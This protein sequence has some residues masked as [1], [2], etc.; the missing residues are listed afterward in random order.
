M[1]SPVRAGSPNKAHTVWCYDCW[2]SDDWEGTDYA[3]EYDDSRPFL[4]Q[5]EEL[6]NDIPKIGLIYV[7]SPGCE[8]T[9]IS[10]D[11][12][13]CYLIIESSNNEDSIHSYWIQEC[14]DVIDTS[15]ASKCERTYE[16]DDCYDCYKVYYSKGSHE[17]RES[18]FLLDCKDCTNCIGCV[19]LRSKKFCIF[20][21]QF[22]KEDYEEKLQELK[23]NTRGGVEKMRSMFD[24]FSKIQP[25]K[26]AEIVNATGSTGDYIKH[27][28]N[29]VSC[30]HC[31]EAED[32]KYAV[33]VWRNAKDCMDVD[34]AGRN[35]V[36]I[37]NSINSGLD[38]FHQIVCAVC[39]G[40]TFSSYSMY[41]MNCNN[42]FGCAGLRKKD[43]CI[44]NKQYTKEEYERITNEIIVKM[45]QEGI[46]GEF[47]PATFSCFGYNETAAPERFPLTKDEAIA[48]GF[49]W[50]DTPR[51]T[52]GKETK[53]WV[54]IPESIAE[55][56]FDVAKEIFTCV[57]CE[58]NY[59]IIPNEYTY[60]KNEG[61]PLPDHCPDCRHNR[62]FLARG[63][64]KL[65]HR[66]CMNAGCMNE[67]ET[68]YAPERE[69]I[70]YC[71][72]CY[73]RV[74]V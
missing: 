72:E 36:R 49:K 22:S 63:P 67:F 54:E 74:V 65:W 11:N 33:H 25:R 20:N 41:A 69:E 18:Y 26:Y 35:A 40:S 56:D 7:K 32:N 62:R 51:G 64:N 37:Y 1:Y 17:C 2:F 38:T 34:T 3:K 42:I 13:N 73:N 5:F 70:I 46:Y 66:S 30:F 48:Q 45:K 50:E 16:C 44:L 43:Y 59:K 53:S 52:F 19:N 27:A 24:V 55:I 57:Q 60:Y 10:A 71:E 8:Y 47:F 61:I 4:E 6:W 15:F 29:C 12:K 31:Y 14:R 28:K 68:S 9:N 39:W 21:E 58:K 23:L